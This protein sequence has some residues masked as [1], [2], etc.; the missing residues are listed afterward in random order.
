ME[1]NTTLLFI[2]IDGK[3]L[4]GRKKRGFG[5]GKYNGIGGKFEAG[6]SADEA[7]IR[8]T[9]EEIGVL[10]KNFE[11]MAI[12]KFDEL[13]K[14]K[15]GKVI[16]HIYLASGYIGELCESEEEEPIWFDESAL[17]Y[18]N[19]FKDDH[20][21]LPKILDGQKLMGDFYYDDNFKLLSHKLRKVK[22]LS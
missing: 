2:R 21:W 8:E 20:Y 6:E 16:M 4:L 18:Y 10:P 7:M 1:I 3:I 13:M 19:M 11:K 9:K 5:A 22:K 14:G 12:I 15:R 17:P